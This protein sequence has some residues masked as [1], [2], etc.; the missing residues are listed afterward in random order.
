M[1]KKQKKTRLKKH[2][3]QSRSTATSQAAAATAVGDLPILQ[4]ARALWAGN[5]LFHALALF[6]RAVAEHPHHLLAV[7]DASRALGEC[8]RIPRALHLLQDAQQ[9][10]GNNAQ[11][12]FLV[13]QSYRILRHPTEAIR[14][15]K[16][17]VQLDP[18]HLDAWLELAL[19]HEHAGELDAALEATHARLRLQPD[20]PET[21]VVRGR[22][23]RRQGSHEQAIELLTK[24][25]Q[26]ERPHW[27]TRSR[28]YSELA[29]TL[30]ARQ[31]YSQ[32]W[33]A[34]VEGKHLGRKHAREYREHRHQQ[35]TTHQ[36]LLESF[37]ESHLR[38][39]QESVSDPQA[40]RTMLLSG[41][42]RSGTTLL[43]TILSRH[44]QIVTADEWN[45]FSR[46]MIP[47]MLSDIPLAEL[48][49]D[50]LSGIAD[51]KLHELRDTYRSFLLAALGAS[52]DADPLLVDKNP[53][54][55]PVLP[56]YLR[57]M[58]RAPLAIM[59][60]DPRDVLISCFMTFSPLNDFSVDFV[61]PDSAAQRVNDDLMNWHSLRERLAGGW[62]EI[63]YE[64]LVTD[65]AQAVAPVLKQFG[66]TAEPTMFD[67]RTPAADLHISAPTYAEATMP[68]YRTA[69]QRWR[70]YQAELEPLLATLE[71]AIEAH[72]YA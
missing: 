5:R 63:R 42:P 1:T 26:A 2:A 16:R 43:E 27:L 21:L 46:F 20:D 41:L 25:A 6:E 4:Q 9:H 14:C 3:A 11:G 49:I 7:V 31:L 19:L 10:L 12:W 18:A 54:L 37:D 50:V 58:P 52:P 53:S 57:L 61:D 32:A 69:N 67:T 8:Y 40:S 64:Q 39:W 51:D 56:T 34:A 45:A 71:P 66:V 33:Q 48:E 15:L 30:D 29:R 62:A 24:V 55:L 28:A 17:A 38:A 70:N 44:S 35:R 59:L 13:G 23:L 60:R 36:Q 72:G 65:P 22:I 47:M 68:I